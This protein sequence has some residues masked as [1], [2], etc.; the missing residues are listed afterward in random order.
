MNKWVDEMINDKCRWAFIVGWLKVS[1][2]GLGMSPEAAEAEIAKAGQ[3]YDKIAA[4]PLG[5]V[6]QEVANGN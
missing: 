4:K 5:E 6:L 2:V 1:L 3:E